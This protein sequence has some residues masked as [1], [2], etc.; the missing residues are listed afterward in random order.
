MSK[1][2]IAVIMAILMVSCIIPF[3]AF[4]DEELVS[5]DT[6]VSGWY[7]NDN[8]IIEKL[9]DNEKSAH[10]KYVA[11]NNED[12]SKTMIT[13]TVF[14]LYDDAWKNGFDKS[15]S[16]DDAEKILCSIIEKVDANFGESK[17]NEIIKVLET[18]SDLNDLLQKV[19]SYV[20]ISDTL[21]SSEWT[22]AFKYINYAIEAGNYYEDSRD[23]VIE[24]YAQIL[25]VQAANDYYKDFLRY[26]AANCEYDVVVTA[27]NNL[28]ANIDKSIDEIMEKEI[29]NVAGFGGSKVFDK[30][31]EIALNTNAYTAVALK[32]YNVGTSVADA[33]WNTSDQYV[34]MDELYTT[35]FV[36]NC[37]VDL[38]PVARATGDY[39]WYEFAINNLLSIR[40]VGCQTLYDL[41][42]AQ[43]EGIV[44]KIKNQINYNIS[45]EQIEELAFLQLAK[46]VLFEIPVESYKPIT[47]IV[48]IN[49]DA[50]VHDSDY[51]LYNQQGIYDGAKG[52]YS[53][54]FNEGTSTFIKTLFM[55]GDDTISLKSGSECYATAVIEKMS[56][57]DIID[58]SFTNEVVGVNKD[59]T[60]NSDI[61]NGAAF[62]VY[63]NDAV[64]TKNMNDDFV[65]PPYNPVTLNAVTTAV[66]DVAQQ[67]VQA[68]VIEIKELISNIFAAIK[69]FFATIFTFK[70]VD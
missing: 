43:N 19:N 35:F 17:L 59:I 3:S 27:A 53:V 50:Y 37:A 56:T 23:K 6:R 4:A 10:W 42:T 14:A 47:S 45:F 66:T 67:E 55:S 12:I 38:V 60:F 49:T 11:E 44:G 28:I 51:S 5:A 24:A 61:T 25:S 41:K 33:L 7:A 46:H 1:K 57:Y 34:L 2:I 26:I 21:T 52:F 20:K 36:E 29:L 69:K 70:A 68:K 65:Y 63:E 48:T 62:T 9:L 13:Y 22:T 58:Y 31:A 54:Y 8:L 15:V 32:V 18:A 64:V 16:V 39:A 40:E 30:A